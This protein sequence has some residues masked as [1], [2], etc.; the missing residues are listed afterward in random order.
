MSNRNIRFWINR[1]LGGGLH[2]YLLLFAVAL[3]SLAAI[4]LCSSMIDTDFW[5]NAYYALGINPVS[6]SDYGHGF[7]WMYLVLGVCGAL[8]FGGLMVT[9]FTSGVERYVERVR[10]GRI[11]YR[12][13]CNHVVIIGWAPVTVGLI[14]GAARKHPNSK[15]LLL[16]PNQPESILAELSASLPAATNK[17]TIIYTTGENAFFQQLKHLCL[18]HAAELFIALG[19][20]SLLP[21]PA[22]QLMLLDAVGKC[23]A[24]RTE[25]LRVNILI[26]NVDTY[27]TLQRCDMHLSNPNVS[28][29]EKQSLDIRL[30]NF[31]ENWARTM[32]GYGGVGQ[33]D[34][35]DFEPIEGSQKHV[36]LVIVGFEDM[37]K[38]LLLEALRICH[39]P[40]EELSRITVID[41][42]AVICREQFQSRFPYL[43][44]IKDICLEFING[45]LE[46]ADIREML[47]KWSDNENKM[48]TIAICSSDP[49]YSLCAALNLPE[50][51]YCHPN[52][53][54]TEGQKGTT[55]HTLVLNS[56]RTRILA[57]QSLLRTI[58]SMVDPLR[59]PN[60]K[61]FGT[62]LPEGADVDLLDDSLAIIINGLYNDNLAGK[63]G[64][65]T[66]TPAHFSRWVELWNSPKVTQD[67]SKH[68][69]RYQS[70]LFRSTIA[71]LQR[72]TALTDPIMMER[73]SEC[74]HRRWIA[75]R[76]LMNWYSTRNGEPRVD[77]LRRHDCLA[78]YDELSE[79]EK[80]KDRNVIKLAQYLAEGKGI[81][82]IGFHF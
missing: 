28:G 3:V 35:L 37:G 49:A 30:F 56:T 22:T 16:N 58:G 25:P 17:R 67:T 20:D 82:R 40:N 14:E 71:I 34:T 31:Y 11:R 74:E 41:N 29:N 75:E 70:D 55:K 36:H 19:E 1:Q 5:W 33:Y 61:L 24:N 57:Q 46:S 73:L 6:E 32:W 2:G 15:I 52:H 47:E 66:I 39:Y 43:E 48:L 69:S 42:N 9:V 4:V 45:S 72:N 63:I 10:S 54:K 18:D 78:D 76:T 7:L 81:L 21:Q 65:D 23:V 79:E 44:A 8:V 12:K 77:S 26:D 62:L 80:Q 51:L 50:R 60:L 59:Y 68:A 13:L 38:A 64:E 27:T 53:I